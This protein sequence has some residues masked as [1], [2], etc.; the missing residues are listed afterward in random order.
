MFLSIKGCTST[1]NFD[2]CYRHVVAY[3]V[4]FDI[5]AIELQSYMVF[6]Y[7][8]DIMEGRL[9]VQGVERVGDIGIVL[10]YHVGSAHHHVFLKL[11]HHYHF[12]SKILGL[13]MYNL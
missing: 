8:R 1:T 11:L 9:V 12:S 10:Q 7:T 13:G 4:F 2:A 6:T 3:E 5:R